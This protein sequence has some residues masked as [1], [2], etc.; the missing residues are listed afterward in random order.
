MGLCPFAS[1]VPGPRLRS[2][3]QFSQIA[4]RAGQIAGHPGDLRA[5]TNDFAARANDIAGRPNG[6]AGHT[7]RPDARAIEFAG[8]P[9]LL[10]ARAIEFAGHQTRPDAYHG[11]PR[12]TAGS[13]G[14]AV[15]ITGEVIRV[16][17]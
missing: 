7:T 12:R 10:A 16:H 3:Q 4:A 15:A 6:F 5:H 2:G 13:G 1:A 14:S 8:H 9:A 17:L 11:P